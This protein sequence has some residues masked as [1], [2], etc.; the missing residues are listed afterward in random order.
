[1]KSNIIIFLILIS[2]N[3]LSANENEIRSR[4]NQWP[5]DFKEK[6][7]TAVCDLF[8]KNLIA[9]Y[10]GVQ[11]KNYQEMCEQLNSIL[12]NSDKNFEYALPEIEEIIIDQNIAIVR[13]I[14][15]L[16]ILDQKTQEK[17]IIRE[18]GLD[19]FEKQKD[20][21]WKIKISYAFP[22]S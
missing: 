15:T 21:T 19:V 6:N 5:Q 22:L 16:T 2:V 18:K 13:L 12:S 7:T 8:A 4:L 11:D 14:W 10:P 20:N 1:M 9:T 3:T 17:E